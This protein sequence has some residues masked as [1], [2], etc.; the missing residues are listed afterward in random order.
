[1]TNTK[2]VAKPVYRKQLR[3]GISI[4]VFE[5]EH[6][7]R[8]YRSINVQRSYKKNGKWER[9]SMYVSHEQIPFLIEVLQSTWTF[10]NDHPIGT[11]GGTN[12]EATE[13]AEDSEDYFEEAEEVAA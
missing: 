8:K 2:S 4:A 3:A 7:G 1:M 11:I 5:N 9:M 12:A 10:L 6:D 13:V